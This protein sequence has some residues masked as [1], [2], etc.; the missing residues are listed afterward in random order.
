MVL[1]RPLI[2]CVPLVGSNAVWLHPEKRRRRDASPQPNLESSCS[3][4]SPYDL[5]REPGE[6]KSHE[7]IFD[8]D[9]QLLGSRLM[10]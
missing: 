5:F 10:L 1:K 2:L 3:F 9:A 4:Y 7:W 8:D 6:E